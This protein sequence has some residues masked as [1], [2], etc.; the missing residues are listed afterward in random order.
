VTTKELEE[1]PFL[2]PAQIAKIFAVK[3]YTVRNWIAQGKFGEKNVIKIGNRLRVRSSA[4][5]AFAESLYGDE[6]TDDFV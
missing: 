3:A 5:T 4:V 2:T 1:D 6:E